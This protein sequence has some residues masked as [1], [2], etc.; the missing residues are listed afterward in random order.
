MTENSTKKRRVP[1]PYPSPLKNNVGWWSLPARWERHAAAEMDCHEKKDKEDKYKGRGPVMNKNRIRIM[2]R[3]IH[4]DGARLLLFN[5]C[6][7]SQFLSLL[8]SSHNLLP[9]YFSS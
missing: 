2:K 1:S 5:Q 3:G 7:A 8:P 4:G 9:V 6:I